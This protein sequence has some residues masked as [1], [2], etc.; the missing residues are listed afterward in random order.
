MDEKVQHQ[1]WEVRSSD[2]INLDPQKARDLVVKCMMESQKET[3]HRVKVKM[4]KVASEEEIEKSIVGAIR[5]VF[6]EVGED[7][8]SPTKLGLIKVVT[9]LAEKAYGWGT[10]KEIIE[11]HKVQMEKVVFAIT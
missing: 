10:P 3:F 5:M 9:R 1:R 11:H 4:G 8:N 7:Y 2:L 6:R